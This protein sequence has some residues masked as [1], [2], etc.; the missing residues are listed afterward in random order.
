MAT[1]LKDE[2]NCADVWE[3]ITDVLQ[4]SDLTLLR[5][6]RD[7]QKFFRLC[8][9]TLDEFPQFYSDLRIVTSDLRTAELLAV[10][11]DSFIKAFLSGAIQVSE[12][13][14]C[15]K[16]FL[17]GGD[18]KYNEIMDDIQVDFNAMKSCTNI[19]DNT[20]PT[21]LQLRRA[22]NNDLPP[23]GYVAPEKAHSQ[24]GGLTK[25][26]PNTGNV[27]LNAY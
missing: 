5:V 18:K 9:D 17:N 22:K 21:K 19:Q 12:L 6:L 14:Q 11:D 2:T 15:T 25:L 4:S 16:Q 13:S 26:P 7:W 8:C 27:I 10:G 1:E 24:T 23:S 20:K 3:K